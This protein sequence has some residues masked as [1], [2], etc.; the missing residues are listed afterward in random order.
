MDITV[1]Q[2]VEYT[3]EQISESAIFT[4]WSKRLPDGWQGSVKILDVGW[5]SNIRV[6][7]M[8]VVH[9]SIPHPVKVNLRSATVDVLVRIRSPR[10]D[11]VVFVKQMREAVPGVVVSN[12]AGGIDSG[13]TPEEAAKRE[14]TEELGLDD[15]SL[16]KYTLEITRLDDD[17]WFASPGIINEEVYF[18]CAT[19]TVKLSDV[20][21]V[22]E[23]LEGKRTGVDAE[24]EDLTLLTI[25]ASEAR[26]TIKGSSN[27]C[28]KTLTSLQLAAGL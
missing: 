1:A 17:P 26:S 18:M 24:G 27:R 13:E 4:N 10:T 21:E 19:L 15:I 9:S 20:D 11:H 5:G 14:L 16:E 6:I 8:E 12:V 25:H 28:L 23:M 7:T 22:L 2:G 3:A